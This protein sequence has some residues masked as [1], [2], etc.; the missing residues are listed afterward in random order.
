M[1]SKIRLVEED[2]L[3]LGNQNIIIYR[4]QNS[5][6]FEKNL[7]LQMQN[8]LNPSPVMKGFNIEITKDNSASF[9][10]ASKNTFQFKG[11]K[12]MA[13]YQGKII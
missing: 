8:N 9:G 2:T 4:Y 5:D 7:L 6:K 11:D 1:R 13:M 12:K 10:R 3:R